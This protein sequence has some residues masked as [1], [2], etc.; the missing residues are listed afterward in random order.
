MADGLENALLRRWYG[1]HAPGVSL[2][3]VAAVYG[4]LMRLRR[5]AYRVGLR[6]VS[7]LPAPV[8][9]VGNRT[10]GGAG[11]TPLVIA[12]VEAL[13]A[14]GWRPGVV[15]RGFGRSLRE[16]LDVR[17][18]IAASAV[19]DE[20]LLVHLT[21][22][23]PVRVDADR[24][25]AARHLIEAGCD[26]VI[27]DDGLQHLR[28]GRRVE[29]EV[30]DARGLGNGFVMPAGPLR[31]PVPARPA[32]FLIVHGREAGEG[33]VPMR[34]NLGEARRAGQG[35]ALPVGTHAAPAD[36]AP[37]S[38]PL[39][40]FIGTPVHA[41]AGIGDPSRF[42]RAL[43][44]AGLAPVEHPFPDHHAFVAEDFAALTGAPIL[45]TGKDAVK[46]RALDLPDAWE[47]PVRALLPEAA[48]DA[49]DHLLKTR[50]TDVDP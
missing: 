44:D 4:G 30:Q 14:R 15:S 27:A 35:S 9:V 12:L 24:T 19:G 39:A 18:D 7:H 1:G 33:E 40:S 46:C 17:A 47:V 32:D 31:E 8:L 38:R 34:L 43:R 16:P 22:G 50:T 42:F 37:S 6:R 13:R 23:A 10:V 11:K 3:A 26:L 20:P 49:I 29:I 28:L 36:I 21:T 5:W 25:A 2:R 45:M 48:I 41:V